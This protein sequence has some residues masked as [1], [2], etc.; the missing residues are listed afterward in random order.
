M[1]YSIERRLAHR[2][3]NE[4]HVYDSD[5]N[6]HDELLCGDQRRYVRERT[7]TGC[8]NDQYTAHRTNN[9]RRLAMRQRNGNIDSQRRDGRP[10]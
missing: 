2:W 3:A 10:I 7:D 5:I 6:H 1:V 8:G 9:N 4:Q